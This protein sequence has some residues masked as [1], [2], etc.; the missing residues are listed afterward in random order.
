MKRLTVA[1]LA[2]LM[3]ASCTTT[4]GGGFALFQ[5]KPETARDALDYYY[6][7]IPDS[8]LPRAPAGLPL[9]D[10][11]TPL[12]RILVASCN[13]EEVESPAL[14]KI[15]SEPGDLFLMIGDNVYG[16]RDGRDY[17]VNDPDLTELKESFAE[18]AGRKEFKAVRAA[19]PMMVAWDD[20]DMGANDGGGDFVFKNFGE[21]IHEVFW[22]L[23][24]QD[25]GAWPGTYYARTFGPE[26]QRTQ[27]IMLDSR[28]FRAPL[29]VTDEYNAKGK[30]RF[31][32]APDGSMQ[33]ML[34]AAQWTWLENQ[35]QQ[36]ADVRLII[37][38]I[39]VLPTVH[40]WESWANMPA[41]RQRLFDL[42]ERSDAKGVVFLSGD[43]HTGFTYKEPGVLPYEANELT[44]SS[45]NVAF[46]KSIDEVDSR[47]IGGGF[48]PENYGAVDIDWEGRTLSLKLMDVAGDIVLQN[49]VAFEDI[50]IE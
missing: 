36:D 32:P 33:D 4:D 15:A 39:Q 12:T 14:A 8:A 37:S 27:I 30:E 9:P 13:D 19:H 11:S 48:T 1:A 43:R 10:A 5:P 44:A 31:M 20:H 3:L 50:G 40:G 49:D 24:D 16:D 35:L 41:E 25:V 42:I 28:F 21:R 45:L 2:G 6:A 38:S 18:L 47:Q 17:S 23:E 26:G 22:G 29:T 34:G 7:T 46:L